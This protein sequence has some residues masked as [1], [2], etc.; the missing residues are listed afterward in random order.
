MVLSRL[1]YVG[2]YAES[3]LL[4]SVAGGSPWLLE[5]GLRA[6]PAPHERAVGER[7]SIPL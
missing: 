1:S 3:S 2:S 5:Y 4:E 7:T 6:A